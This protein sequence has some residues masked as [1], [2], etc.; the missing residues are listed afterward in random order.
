MMTLCLLLCGLRRTGR[1]AEPAADACGRSI[2]SMSGCDMDGGGH[3]RHSPALDWYG[4]ASRCDYVPGGGEHRG[5]A[6]SR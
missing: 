4:H 5:G 1:Q 6:G 2:R 3:L